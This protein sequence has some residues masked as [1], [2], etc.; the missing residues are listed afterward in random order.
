MHYPFLPALKTYAV[1]CTSR[2][3]E[4]NRSIIITSFNVL[5]A[6]EFTMQLALSLPISSLFGC[7]GTIGHDDLRRYNNHGPFIISS[8]SPLAHPLE[9]KSAALFCALGT[10][11]HILARW[12]SYISTTLFITY[13][14]Y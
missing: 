2:L 5:L 7:V 3:H 8:K 6:T 10:Y 4:L 9:I 14:L 11:L 12:S 1:T 13:G